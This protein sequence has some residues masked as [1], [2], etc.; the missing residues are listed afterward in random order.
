MFCAMCVSHRIINIF[1][2]STVYQRFDIKKMT[3]HILVGLKTTRYL[4]LGDFRDS[5]LGHMMSKEFRAEL[6]GNV[7]KCTVCSKEHKSKTL[8]RDHVE[9]K[10]HHSSVEICFS[11]SRPSI[12]R[13][14][15]THVII[16]EKFTRQEIRSRSTL[17]CTSETQGSRAEGH[18]TP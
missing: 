17:Q 16:V 10:H 5:L 4:Y 1:A 15:I 12:L 9:V 3:A 13:T 8:I 14:L 18:T 6:G 11:L 2:V 7:W